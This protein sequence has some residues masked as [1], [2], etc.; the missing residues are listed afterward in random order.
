[1]GIEQSI[2]S[3]HSAQ[4]Y[5]DHWEDFRDFIAYNPGARH[6]R[7]LTMALLDTLEF[8]SCLD[9]GCG[10]GEML[11]Q[12]RS[13]YPYAS[14]KGAD[15]SEQVLQR[16]RELFPSCSF[17]PLDIE[18]QSFKEQFDLVTCCEVVEHLSD[19]KAAFANLASMVAPGG[20][21]L[22]TCPSGKVFA[23]E[24][25]FGHTSHPTY[26]ELRSHAE[27][28]GLTMRSFWNW[29]FP[30]YRLVKI[31]TNINPKFSMRHFGSGPYSFKQR[32]CC[33][34]LY[35]LNFLNR[36]SSPQGCQVFCLMQK[37]SAGSD[38]VQVSRMV[39]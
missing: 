29:G 22:I 33:L 9:V 23:T 16:N 20:Y 19:R 8:K 1:M 12:L 36:R 30:F 38:P 17:A 2:I 15:Y 18:K 6:R 34:L 4:D 24:K 13:K 32:M 31:A 39:K 14:L 28:N 7:R 35:W 11:R 37:A 5:D 21:L 10:T 27:S 26:E 25:F 3:F